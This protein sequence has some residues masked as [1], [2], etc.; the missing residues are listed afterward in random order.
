MPA[1]SVA[2]AKDMLRH[3]NQWQKKPCRFALEELPNKAP[4]LML[5][6]LASSGIERKYI[7][8]SFIGQFTFA[9]YYRDDMMDT[10]DKLSAYDTL[11]ALAYWLENSPLPILGGKR[12]ALKIEQTATPALAQTDD[13][14][15]DYQ[16]IFSLRYKQSV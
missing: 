7:D 15:E 6:P 11:E 9:V 1:D 8:G 14:T 4:A 10:A 13:D 3:L 5:Q 2:V 16:T 12:I